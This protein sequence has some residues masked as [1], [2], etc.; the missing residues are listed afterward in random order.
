MA[1]AS[2]YLCGFVS[3]ACAELTTL[4]IDSAKVKLQLDPL[5]KV[6]TSPLQTVKQMYNTNHSFWPGAS[7]ATIRAGIF[8][9]IRLGV[10]E[11]TLNHVTNV[12]G[13]SQG[14]LLAKCVT[15]IPVSAI[16]ITFA[17]PWDVIKVRCQRNSKYTQS[18]LFAADPRVLLKIS[19]E[20]GFFRGLYSGYSANLLRNII[21]GSSELVAYFH[22]KQVIMKRLNWADDTKTHVA[23]S[24]CS[25]LT[26]TVLGSPMDV[27]G[28]RLM[29]ESAVAEGLSAP[30]YVARIIKEEGF[31]SLYKGFF[32]NWARIGTF[33]L[34][35]FVTFEKVQDIFEQR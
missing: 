23:S 22:S 11:D 3:A 12:L 27:L 5:G 20:E 9:A 28:T 6:Y 21:I 14:S 35:L 34:I 33:N 30:K 19:K 17:N 26:A 1:Q 10:Y 32:F 24:L 8:N 29:Q 4:P 13:L 31:K 15:A 16:S 7:V 2:D 25:G 18:F